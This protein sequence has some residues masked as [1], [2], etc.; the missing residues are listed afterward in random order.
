MARVHLLCSYNPKKGQQLPYDIIPVRE[1]RR[2]SG[3]G[4]CGED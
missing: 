2:H 3:E 1:T 4:N